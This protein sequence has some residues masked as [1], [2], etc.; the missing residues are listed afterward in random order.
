M[1]YCESQIL[2]EDFDVAGTEFHLHY[3]S[4]RVPG[5]KVGN[6]LRIPLSGT[7]VPAS[8][9]RIERVIE[10]AG[11]RFEATYSNAT[12]QVSIF[13]WDGKDAYGRYLQGS[14][15]VTV[16]IGYVYP[17][18]YQA[19][20][21]S[22]RTFGMSSGIGYEANPARMEVTIWQYYTTYL[23]AVD[24]AAV[25]WG[26][27]TLDIHH[28]FD[29]RRRMLFRGDGTVSGG[30]ALGD[31]ISSYA[32]TGE[33]CY[34]DCGVG[35]PAAYAKLY[36]PRS[37]DL[38]PDGTLY[39]AGYDGVKRI[40]PQ[41]YIYAVP[42][43]DKTFTWSLAVA[44]DGSIFVVEDAK[45]DNVSY[46]RI[47]RVARDGSRTVVAGEGGRCQPWQA[48]VDCGD[49]GPALDAK[50]NY[51]F[52]MATGPDGSLYVNDNTGRIRRIGTDG[53]INTVAG[54][55]PSCNYGSDR[56]NPTCGDEGP[57]K[58]AGFYNPE[59]IDV[60]PDGSLYIVDAENALIR[61]VTPDGI[62]H[63]IAGT[64]QAGFSGDGGPA[65][66]AKIDPAL[67]GIAVGRDGSVF[68]TDSRNSR[69]RRIGRDGIITTVAGSGAGGL[70]GGGYAGD[71]GPAQRALLDWPVDVAVAPDGTLFIADRENDR[72]RRVGP[73]LG[74]GADSS[75]ALGGALRVAQAP[76]GL[77][78]ATIPAGHIAIPSEDGSELYEFDTNVRHVRTLNALT[79]D[80]RY[81]FEYDGAGRL[82][83]V[84]D[85]AGNHTTIERDGAG[86]PTAIVAP[87]GQR[88]PLVADA[89][90]YL[91]Q[92]ANPASEG[93]GLTYTPEGLLTRL[94]DQGGKEH[95]FSYDDLGRLTQDTGPDGR[96]TTLTRVD[97]LAGFQVTVASAE[98]R[99]TVYKQETLPDGS[100]R[101]TT[102]DPTGGQTVVETA[103]D[104]TRRVTYPDGMQATLEFGPDPRWGTR[105]PILT[106]LTARTPAGRTVT[107]LA[108]RIVTLSDPLNPLSVL[109]QTDTITVANRVSTTAYDAAARRLTITS[110]EGR[111]SSTTFDPLGRVSSQQ[112]GDGT[113]ALQFTYDARGRLS[114]AQ[115]GNQTLTYGYDDLNRLTSRSDGARATTMTYDAAGRLA[116]VRLPSGRTYAY[117]Y[118]VYGNRI[119]VK[120]PSGALHSLSNTSYGDLA[121]YTPPGS[122]AAYASTYNRDGERTQVQ[123]PSGATQTYNRDTA[124]RVNTVTDSIATITVGYV[125]SSALVSTLTRTPAGGGTGQQLGWTY[126][127]AF[128]TGL[129]YS[130][131]ANGS[132]GY[133]WGDDWLLAG[134]TVAGTPELAIAH[135]RDGLL[136]AT[137]A[138]GFTRGGPQGATSAIADTALNL[139][140]SYDTHGRQ[141]GRRTTVAGQTR[142]EWSLTYDATGRLTGKTETVGGV[143][144]S[145]VY[146]Y[147]FDGQLVTV[148]R[149]GSPV[150][151]Y[152]YDL[153]GNRTS[154]GAT[155]DTQERLAT[156][157]ATSYSFNA[158]GFMIAR[159][160]DSFQYGLQGELLRA[161]VGGQVVTYGYDGFGRR[162]SRTDAAGTTQ[163]LYGNPDDDLQLTA[164]RD[165]AGA[166]T[167][168]LYDDSGGLVALERGGQRYYVGIDQVGSPRVVVDAAGTIVKTITYD[169]FGVQTGSTGTFALPIGYAG[170]LSDPLTGLVR[171]G[172]RDYEP[173]SGRWTSRDPALFQSGQYN[174]YAYV[175]N[176]PSIGRDP[177]GLTAFGGSVCSGICGGGKLAW[178]K[179]GGSLSIE[180]GVGTPSVSLESNPDPNGG[181]EKDGL[182]VYGQASFRAGPVTGIAKIQSKMDDCG[183]FQSPEFKPKACLGPFCY[184]NDKGLETKV[185]PRK[186]LDQ[187]KGVGTPGV[188][189]GIK[190]DM[191]LW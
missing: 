88:T 111:K 70:S 186:G 179:E 133:R 157:G 94:V 86:N 166:L 21:N 30:D 63:S 45:R 95:T 67:G 83:G 114:T 99:T 35:G 181:L 2:G 64:G 106:S 1:I 69:V 171:F 82:A 165:A 134:L 112:P 150:E 84:R 13:T 109:S 66:S 28:N 117:T 80:L 49:G 180:L 68:F 107:R 18:V 15:P 139:T 53:I 85:V 96:S 75:T 47:V 23:G 110:P 14:Q 119:S 58:D 101:R 59:G 9:K 161:T 123:L 116:T 189:G 182:A 115:Q 56:N 74:N 172:M 65:R 89:N 136:T 149:N 76:A 57:A 163:Y 142:Y 152:V 77:L 6:T 144:N 132:F 184:S 131:L 72:V 187:W 36:Q 60:G 81:T 185:D 11:N 175:D 44:R 19:P 190:L 20:N 158:D 32:G 162:V 167:V 8:L 50:F 130:G 155:Y 92:I 146:G 151:N 98:G 16:R 93:F 169:T 126:D 188:K 27:W 39:V 120:L 100:S 159:G 108:S 104:G 124:G 138:L 183:D 61:K 42:G 37:V 41:G 24:A 137:G 173:A 25:G 91:T 127:G 135:D 147:D 164:S 71:G 156:R 174:L 168:Y 128:Q 129:T 43:L 62:M 125:P 5:Y 31:V 103:T 105:S 153:N 122:P 141:T 4:D 154:G 140:L 73:S 87:G 3:S 145:F 17:A 22:G 29:P 118:D 34:V 121:A 97:A 178:T 55:G 51:V 170:G 26:G 191:R 12:N 40:D 176:R 33:Q 46:E 143:P 52:G 7:S 90:G 148:M 160:A 38:A 54:Y 102:T 48:N 177:T 113:D 79:G 78:A 10:V